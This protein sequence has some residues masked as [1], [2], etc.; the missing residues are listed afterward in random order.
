MMPEQIE[1]ALE[2]LHL[3]KLITKEEI[4]R[5]YRYLTK[6][7]HPDRCTE[8]DEKIKRINEAYALLMRYIEEFRY[9]FDEDEIARQLPGEK[10]EQRFKR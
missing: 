9:T 10:H 8:D 2:T 7:Y 6:K 4:K 5:Q 3:P 1:E